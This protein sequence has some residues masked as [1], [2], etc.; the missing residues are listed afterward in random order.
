[1]TI[2]RKPPATLESRMNFGFEWTIQ[3]WFLKFVPRLITNSPI[4]RQSLCWG[5]PR[6]SATVL[7]SPSPVDHRITHEESSSVLP[8][9]TTS[10]PG[11]SDGPGAQI[12]S[13]V[14]II[15][16]CPESL[17]KPAIRKA[18]A[19]STCSDHSAI[20]LTLDGRRDSV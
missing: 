12:F 11:T 16:G 14:W 10:S 17:P 2:L 15:I 4:P 19:V 7:K 8:P 1:M 18:A 20:S 13:N 6:T 5:H 3:G 9:P